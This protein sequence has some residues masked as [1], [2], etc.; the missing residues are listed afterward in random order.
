MLQ[1]SD[2]DKRELETLMR[3]AEKPHIRMKTAA[4]WNLSRG[5]TQREV[6][7]FLGVS[8][9]SVIAWVKRFRAEGVGG[10]AIRPG[11][12]RP[13]KVSRSQVE[14]YLRQSPRAFG[15][16]QTRWTLRALARV[17]PSLVGFSDMG[18]WKALNRMGFR[19]KR[20]QPH[21]HSPDPEYQE[22]RGSWSRP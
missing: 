19:Y 14:N 2:G 10:L 17:A 15:L 3:K 5:K 11:R 21:L 20:G 13:A 7:E 1:L 8:R 16:N 9:T 4:L 18:V 22:K 12:G 6:A